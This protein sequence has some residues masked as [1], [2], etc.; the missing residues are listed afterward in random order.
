MTVTIEIYPD[1][2]ELYDV[3]TETLPAPLAGES[4]LQYIV[5]ARLGKEEDILA[6]VNGASRSVSYILRDGD[7]LKIYPLAASG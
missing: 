7:A 2:A 3:D 6:V 1:Y 4:V 5:R